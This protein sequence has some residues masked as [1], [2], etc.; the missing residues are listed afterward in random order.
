MIARDIVLRVLRRIRDGRL[1]I[2]EGGHRHELGTGEPHAL[3][4]VA[5]P[6]AWRALLRGSRG[7]AESYVD[8]HWD[9]PDLVAVI[10]IAARNAGALDRARQR[11]TPIREPYQRARGALTR[12]TPRAAARTSPPTTTSATS[13]SG[14]CSTRR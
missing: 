13:C 1:T 14:S 8:G 5:D 2:V 9:S 6:R 7:L 12:N 4:H 11:L 10:R 3:V